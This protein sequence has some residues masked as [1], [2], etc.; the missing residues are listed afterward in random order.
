MGGC[1]EGVICTVAMV[2]FHWML[3]IVMMCGISHWLLL[4]AV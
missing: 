3:S 2:S 4:N 1:C